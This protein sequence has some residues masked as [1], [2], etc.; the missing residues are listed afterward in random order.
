MGTEF[1]LKFSA[2]PHVLDRLR[3]QI[4]GE[5]QQLRMETTY[6]DTSDGALALRRYTLRRRLENGVSVCTVK[7]PKGELER[8][9]WD[10]VCTDICQ[11]VP[12]LCRMGAPKELEALTA[13]GVEPVC[14]ARFLRWACKL[15]LG[16]TQVEL[17]LDEGVLFAGEREI[18]L[19]EV[20][21]EWKRGCRDTAVAFAHRLAERWGLEPEHRSKF[22]RALDL[23]A[24]GE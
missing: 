19:C 11:A 16:E 12:R 18:P 6:Y 13:G 15:E 7:T 9:E 2:Q 23:R 10:T 5:W 8:G 24:K 1:E 22:R 14:G 21:I 20:E 3:Q 4:Q 17:A